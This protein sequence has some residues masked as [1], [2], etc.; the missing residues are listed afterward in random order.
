MSRIDHCTNLIHFT[1]GKKIK[2]NY[3]EAYQTLKKIITEK[4]IISSNR[5]ISGKHNCIC[6][7]ETPA[8]CLT[9][10][11]LL[12]AKYFSRYTPFGIQFSKKQIFNN[13][14]RPVIYSTKS[15]YILEEKNDNLNWRYV[16]Y[17]P[18]DDGKSDFTWEREW[19]IKS[20]KLTFENSEVKLLFPNITWINRFILEHDIEY[21]R[22]G[23]NANC[24][25]CFCTREAKIYNFVDLVKPETCEFISGTCPDNSKFPWILINMN[26]KDS[27]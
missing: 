1:K 5:M 16:T 7:T 14:G 2:T 3:E 9:N 20:Q 27:H 6:F 11:G 12:D 23:I 21:H 24:D 10:D 15:E 26:E 19:R 18:N 17:D 22:S 13:D 4:T 25:A 8:K